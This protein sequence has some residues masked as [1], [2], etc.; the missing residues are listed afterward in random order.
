MHSTKR[1]ALSEPFTVRSCPLSLLYFW[2]CQCI[3]L[4]FRLESV[5]EKFAETA[6]EFER[7]KKSARKTKQVFEKVKKERFDRFNQCFEKVADRIDDIYKVCYVITLVA[8]IVD[9]R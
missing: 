8:A 7:A 9:I 3:V 5:Q 2:G 1:E 6:D 4:D